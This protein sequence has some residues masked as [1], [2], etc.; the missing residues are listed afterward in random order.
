MQ[1]KNLVIIESWKRDRQNQ[2]LTAPKRITLNA[3]VSKVVIRD[4]INDDCSDEGW[5]NVDGEED[6]NDNGKE[7]EVEF[8]KMFSLKYH[9][10][11]TPM[12]TNE[13][14]QN[15]VEYQILLVNGR[16]SSTYYN[17]FWEDCNKK[18]TN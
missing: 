11:A 1:H 15:L 4:M 10:N 17:N 18:D 7:F 3:K 6:L 14:L 5:K 9:P 13:S 16:S 12:I 8:G 2:N